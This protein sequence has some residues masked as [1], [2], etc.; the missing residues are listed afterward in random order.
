MNM[1][2]YIYSRYALCTFRETN[3][4]LIGYKFTIVAIFKTH[5]QLVHFILEVVG[6][7]SWQ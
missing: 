1:N 7:Y 4:W 2:V 3:C 5:L 6:P